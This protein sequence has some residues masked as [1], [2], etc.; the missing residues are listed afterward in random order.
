MAVIKTISGSVSAHVVA[1]RYDQF[2][3]SY[4]T[5][6]DRLTGILGRGKANPGALGQFVEVEA[7]LLEEN[8]PWIAGADELLKDVASQPGSSSPKGEPVP[9][10]QRPLGDRH[11][12]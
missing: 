7:A 5:T 9:A 3:V 10:W 11:S 2:T 1:E 12:E 6:A 4:R 8:Q